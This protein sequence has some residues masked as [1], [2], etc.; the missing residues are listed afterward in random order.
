MLAHAMAWHHSC[1]KFKAQL[2][3]QLLQCVLMYKRAIPD[4]SDG[5][6]KKAFS[7]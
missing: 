1:S 5:Q 2:Q 4:K 6:F 3:L 7:E